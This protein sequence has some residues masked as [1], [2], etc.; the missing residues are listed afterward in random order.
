MKLKRPWAVEALQIASRFAG[1]PE[2]EALE[3]PRAAHGGE[4]LET[5]RPRRPRRSGILSD[6]FGAVRAGIPGPRVAA[7]LGAD[8]ALVELALEHLTARGLVTEAGSL[9]LGCATC[10]PPENRPPTCKACPF[11]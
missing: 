8:P 10:P 9:G 2:V 5:P 3:T 1:D 4:A 7:H 11:G 6:V